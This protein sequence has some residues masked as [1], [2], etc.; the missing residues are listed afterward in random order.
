MTTPLPFNSPAP[1]PGDA[2]HP[3]GTPG[4]V[5][6]HRVKW[7]AI[8]V[9]VTLIATIGVA[10]V[11]V[12]L[13]Q[14]PA[15]A[16]AQ[17]KARITA[18]EAFFLDV[19]TVQEYENGHLPGATNIPVDEIPHRLAEIPRD[20]PVICYCTVGVRSASAADQLRSLGYDAH[21]FGGMNN[22]DSTP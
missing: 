3:N 2:S 19:R 16:I 9:V 17:M 22:W 12:V 6:S 14:P 13:M 20:K 7:A 15:D 4:N 11:A 8:G 5:W 10:Y 21:N 18:G 1:S